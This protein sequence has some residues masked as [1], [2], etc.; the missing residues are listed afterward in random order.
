MRQTL[1]KTK[2]TQ[3]MNKSKISMKHEVVTKLEH[4]LRELMA[5][6]KYDEQIAELAAKCFWCD[7][8]SAKVIVAQIEKEC[9]SAGAKLDRITSKIAS[10]QSN[11]ADLGS[12]ESMVGRMQ[13][14]NAELD[15]AV[16]EVKKCEQEL[17][18]ATR[19]ATSSESRHHQSRA[20]GLLLVTSKTSTE[21]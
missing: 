13:E 11:L 20:S 3:Q 1:D 17:L 16:D 10:L 19:A 6:D 9:A 15:A 14:L 12:T 8:Y 7:V 21:E 18:E 5:L 2:E 4:E